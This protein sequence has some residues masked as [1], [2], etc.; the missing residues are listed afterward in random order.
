MTPLGFVAIV[1]LLAGYPDAALAVAVAAVL[2]VPLLAIV[3]GALLARAGRPAWGYLT[4]PLVAAAL[5]FQN[6]VVGQLATLL[7][8]A[9]SCV[10]LGALLRCVGDPRALMTGVAVLA[11]ADVILLV[12][13]PVNEATAALRAVNLGNLPGFQEA[14]VGPST[15]GYGDLFVA[16]VAGAIAART[17]GAPRR[18]GV[19]TL[20]FALLESALFF[21]HGPYPSTV[22]VVLALAVEETWRRVALRRAVPAL[23]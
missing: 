16:G 15:M 13:G 17:P 19:L 23:R 2:G 5:L 21:R 18:V 3:A 20:V 7:L 10:A 22:P 14:V 9:L 6:H 12:A 4:A 1:A 8:L 11:V